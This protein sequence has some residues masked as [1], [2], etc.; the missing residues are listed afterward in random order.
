ML[1]QL[2]RVVYNGVEQNRTGRLVRSPFLKAH[3]VEKDRV[4]DDG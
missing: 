3:R 1:Q 4:I 2:T